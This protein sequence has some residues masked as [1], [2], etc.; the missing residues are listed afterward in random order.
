MEGESQ[1]CDSATL[2]GAELMKIAFLGTGIM[3]APMA[4]NLA[5]A[6]HDVTVWNRT[7]ERAQIAGTRQ[8]PTPS[9]AVAD[10]EVAWLCVSDHHAVEQVLFGA[11]GLA[12]G[13]PAGL[14]VADSSTI[15]P[16]A[17]R[18]FAT[19]LAAQKVTYFDCP[20][21]GSKTG[22]ENAEL[23]F[24]VGGPKATVDQLQPLFGAMGKK[25]IYIGE[26]G[27]GV[28]AKLAMNLNL[29]LIYEGFAEGLMLAQ[30]AGVQPEQMIELIGASM[31]RSGVVERKGPAVLK[32]DFSPQFPLHLMLKDIHLMLEQ[33]RE[34]R[35]KLPALETVEEVYSIAAEE[36]FADQDFAATLLLLEKWAGLNAEARSAAD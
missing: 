30:K 19:R 29:A 26:T 7:P 21:T 13:A 22:A 18:S 12:A 6:G 33:A 11:D 3:G 28:S 8:A 5:K 1:L 16:K 31:L 23:V 25:V 17:T 35:V 20:V 9:A 4:A 32:R 36:G 24:I 14:I 27:M 2:I 34:L 15:L 10:A